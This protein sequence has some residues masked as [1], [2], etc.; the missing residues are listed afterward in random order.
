V[1]KIREELFRLTQRYEKF[2]EQ[3]SSEYDLVLLDC[4]PGFDLETLAAMHVAGG[5]II[6][7]NPDY[8]SVVTAIRLSEYAKKIRMPVGGLILNKIRNKKYELTKP[9]IEKALEMKIIQEIPYDKKIPESIARKKP[10]V[11]FR[12][13]SKSG[14]AFR[15]LAASIIGQESKKSLIK[16]RVKIR[17]NKI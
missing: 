6:V 14:K 13:N 9:E 8:P 7:T 11:L 16:K 5:M 4:A 10:V 15:R 1:E 12:K 3:L 2:L 17:K